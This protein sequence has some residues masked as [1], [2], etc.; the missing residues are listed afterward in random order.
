MKATSEI[1][2]QIQEKLSWVCE[3]TNTHRSEWEIDYDEYEIR[4]SHKRYGV[5][6]F[7]IE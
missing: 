3:E 4:L 2:M 6:I 5:Y 7:P 1:K